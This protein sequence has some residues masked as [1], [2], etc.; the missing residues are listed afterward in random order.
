MSKKKRK[1]EIKQ[2]DDALS[3]VLN[4]SRMLVYDVAEHL[5]G[6]PEEDLRDSARVFISYWNKMIATQNLGSEYLIPPRLVHRK[7]E[8]G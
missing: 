1:K 4:A 7:E 6:G 5:H 2:K 3:Q 8:V